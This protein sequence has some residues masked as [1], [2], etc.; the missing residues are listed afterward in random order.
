MSKRSAR[1]IVGIILIAAALSACAD[2]NNQ[3]SYAEALQSRPMPDSVESRQQECGWIRGEMA[4]Q[5]SLAQV[6]GAMATSPMMAMA[7]QAAAGKNLAALETRAANIGCN[8]AFSSTPQQADSFD[9]CFARCIIHGLPQD[10]V[11]FGV[12]HQHKHGM[13]TG[14]D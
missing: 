14:N 5:R 6:G 7:Y 1:H 8:A 12:L 13:P 10:F 4:R 3:Q 11:V 2:Q 9:Q